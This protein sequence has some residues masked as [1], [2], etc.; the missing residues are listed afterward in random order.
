MAKDK[1]PTLEDD[2]DDDFGDDL[3]G[4]FNSNDAGDYSGGLG[5]EDGEDPRESRHPILKVAGDYSG[6]VGTSTL[7]GVGA[8]MADAFKDKMPNTSR[9]LGDLKNVA[10]EILR[11]KDDV[12]KDIRPTITQ[13]KVTLRRLAKYGEEV[14]PTGI[15]NRINKWLETQEED[16]KEPQSKEEARDQALSD[17]LNT[18]FEARLKVEQSNRKQDAIRE[19]ANNRIA[20]SRHAELAGLTADIRNQAMY[21]TAFLRST[22]TAYLRKD[23]ELKYRQL[24]LTEDIFETM[25]AQTQMQEDRLDAIIHNTALPDMAKVTLMDDVKFKFKEKLLNSFT[26][27]TSSYM[28]GIVNKIKENYVE[29]LKDNLGNVNDILGTFLDMKEMEEEMGMGS[30]PGGVKKSLVGALTGWLANTFIGKPT[31][32]K[33]LSKMP[34]DMLRRMEGFSK[35]GSTRMKLLLEQFRNG[36]IKSDWLNKHEDLASFLKDLADSVLPEID[37]GAGK[38]LN[39][40]YADPNAAGMIT[41]KFTSTVEE[42]IPGYL[43][44]QTNLL[45]AIATNQG[46]KATG[47]YKIYDWKTRK[48]I[49][50]KDF[51]N[52][53]ITE[54][55]GTKEENANIA[56]YN[57]EA[58]QKS[59]SYKALMDKDQ[60]KAVEISEMVEYEDLDTDLA[61]F[62]TLVA[63]QLRF[64][65][66]FPI[67]DVRNYADGDYDG[68]A[69]S[70]GKKIDRRETEAGFTEEDMPEWIKDVFLSGQIKHPKVLARYLTVICLTK[71]GNTTGV[72]TDLTNRIIDLIRQGVPQRAAKALRRM[73]DLGQTWLLTDE[74]AGYGGA[75]VNANTE[76]DIL[77]VSKTAR[78]HYSSQIGQKDLEMDL[79]YKDDGTLLK[80]PDKNGWTVFSKYWKKKG[81][82]QGIL[83]RAAQ[84]YSGLTGLA[85]GYR[86]LSEG[87]S[88]AMQTFRDGVERL[89]DTALERMKGHMGPWLYKMLSTDDLLPLRDCL[90]DPVRDWHDAEFREEITH[91]EVKR[92]L[93]AYPS[94]LDALLDLRS[95]PNTFKSIISEGLPEWLADMIDEIASDP[96]QV[97]KIRKYYSPAAIAERKKR[98]AERDLAEAGRIFTDLSDRIKNKK[99]LPQD[100]IAKVTRDDIRK[101]ARENNLSY[102]D[103]RKILNDQRNEKV[104]EIT[105]KQEEYFE[106]L[107]NRLIATYGKNPEERTEEQKKEMKRIVEFLKRFKNIPRVKSILSDHESIM[108]DEE[109]E[110]KEKEKEAEKAKKNEGK[111]SKEAKKARAKAD[112]ARIKAINKG[113]EARTKIEEMYAA[114]N[115]SNTPLDQEKLAKLKEQLN[116]GKEAQRQQDQ[117]EADKQAEE[118]RKAEEKKQKDAQDALNEIIEKYEKKDIELANDIVLGK[119]KSKKDPY[120]RS[121]NEEAKL[122]L[123]QEKRKALFD[124][125]RK[126]GGPLHKNPELWEQI[127]EL[128]DAIEQQ[129]YKHSKAVEQDAL[130]GPRHAAT[131]AEIDKK[132]QYD[133]EHRFDPTKGEE[134]EAIRSQLKATGRRAYVGV[135]NATLQKAYDDAYKQAY[136]NALNQFDDTDV[137]EK[138][139][140]TVAEALAIT[141]ARERGN[142][143]REKSIHMQVRGDTTHIARSDIQ[144]SDTELER[145]LK[146]TADIEE[147]TI[148]NPLRS[149]SGNIIKR[150]A[151]GTFLSRMFNKVSSADD[152]L[153]RG[154][155]SQAASIYKGNPTPEGKRLADACTSKAN[156]ILALYAQQGV[157]ISKYKKTY[158]GIVNTPTMLD[159]INL[160]GEHGK[161]AIIPLNS[162]QRSKE[163]AEETVKHTHGAQAA[164]ALKDA[165]EAKGPV[166]GEQKEAETVRDPGTILKDIE[167]GIQQGGTIIQGDKVIQD[168][169]WRPMMQSLFEELNKSIQ[170]TPDGSA[171]TSFRKQRENIRRRF[172]TQVSKLPD[173]RESEKGGLFNKL[174][175]KA[176]GLFAKGEKYVKNVQKEYYKDKAREAGI[177]DTAKAV[178]KDLGDTESTKASEIWDDLPNK[179]DGI[180]KS[181]KK[182]IALLKRIKK[183]GLREQLSTADQQTLDRITAAL[184]NKDL[185]LSRVSIAR[186]TSPKL[187]EFIR[188]Y[189]EKAKTL[190]EKK[191]S[192]LMSEAADY[193][194]GKATAAK[195]SIKE[196]YARVRESE[197]G[198]AVEGAAADAKEIATKSAKWGIEKLKEGAGLVG[199]LWNSVSR[200]WHGTFVN[201]EYGGLA[202]IAA[203]QLQIQ[204]GI[205]LQLQAGIPKAGEVS[206]EEA[207]SRL[208]ALSKKMGSWRRTGWEKIKSGTSWLWKT[209]VVSPAKGTLSTMRH[210][211]FN[212]KD[213]VYL[214]PGAGQ[215]PCQDDLLLISEEDFKKGVFFDKKGMHKVRSIQDINRPV[216]DA[217]GNVLIE[218]HHIKRGLTDSKGNPIRSRSRM[219]GRLLH[220]GT[221]GLAETA[222][223]VGKWG[224]GKIFNMENVRRVK[225]FF[226]S[227][228]GVLGGFL[229]KFE[230]IYNATKLA[231]AKTDDERAE[232]L[233]V[234]AKAQENGLVEFAN[235]KKPKDSYSIDSPLYWTKDKANGKRA[236]KVAITQVDIDEGLVNQDGTKLTS[237]LRKIGSVAR[238]MANAA[239]NFVGGLIGSPFKAVGTI[240]SGLWGATKWLFKGKDPYVDV[241]IPTKSGK[242]KGEIRRGHPRLTSMGIKA[243][244]YIYEDGTVVKSAW[245]LKDM[246][247]LDAET[248]KVIIKKEDIPLA[249]DIDGKPLTAFRGASVMGK[250]GRAG[251]AA[252][253][254][255]GR[256]VWKGVKGVGRFIKAGVNFITKGMWNTGSDIAN[257]VVESTK[258]ILSS[259]FGTGEKPLIRKDLEEIVGHRLV[260][261]NEHLTDIFLLLEDRLA[262]QT[263]KGDNNGT[264]ARDGSYQDYVKRMRA[265]RQ[266]RLDR[267]AKAEAARKK[268]ENGEDLTAEELA[269]LAAEAG[270]KAG[271]EAGDDGSML[272]TAASAALLYSLLPAKLKGAIRWPAKML[273]KLLPKKLGG[274]WL[275]R[276]S[277]AGEVADRFG[278]RA[279]QKAGQQGAGWWTRRKAYSQ[280][281]D[282]ARSK[283]MRRAATQA[284]RNAGKSALASVATKQGAKMGVRSLF[285]VGKGIGG[286]ASL[287]IGLVVGTIL[288][289]VVMDTWNHLDGTTAKRDDWEKMRFSAYGLSDFAVGKD[290][291]NTAGGTFTSA[292]NNNVNVIRDYVEDLEQEALSLMDGKREPFTDSD[293][294]DFCQDFKLLKSWY[295][296]GEDRFSAGLRESTFAKKQGGKVKQDSDAQRK[297]FFREWLEKRFFPI[298]T[299]YVYVMRSTIGDETEEDI[300][301]PATTL[302]PDLNQNAFKNF[303]EGIKEL[304]KRSPDTKE[305]S[306]SPDGYVYYLSMKY[307]DAEVQEEVKKRREQGERHVE[308]NTKKTYLDQKKEAREERQEWED[309]DR[310]DTDA[311]KLS[312][313]KSILAR[314]NAGTQDK[315]TDEMALHAESMRQA[316]TNVKADIEKSAELAAIQAGIANYT[317]D[318]YN[319][320]AVGE[321]I[322]RWYKVKYELYGADIKTQAAGINALESF[323]TDVYFNRTA[324]MNNDQAEK[325][326]AM[327]GLGEAKVTTQTAET[328]PVEEMSLDEIKNLSTE[329]GEDTEEAKRRRI[330]YFIN[331]Y[332]LR[333]WPIFKIYVAIIS[334]FLKRDTQLTLKD[335]KAADNDVAF[336][337]F[338]TEAKAVLSKNPELENLTPSLAGYNQL[339]SKLKAEVEK[340]MTETTGVKNPEEEKSP[341]DVAKA[342]EEAKRRESARLAAERERNKLNHDRLMESARKADAAKAAA[343]GGIPKPPTTTT[344][345]QTQTQNK[346]IENANK[347]ATDRALA[348]AEQNLSGQNGNVNDKGSSTGGAGADAG[349]VIDLSHIKASDIPDGG[350][351]DIGSYV[352]Q[353]E[354]GKKGPSAIGWDKGGG[355][356]YGSYQLAAGQNVKMI[357]DEFIPWLKSHGGEFGKQL[358]A[359]LEQNKPYD[360]GSTHGKAP[361][362]WRQFAGVEGGQALNKLEHKFWYEKKYLPILKRLSK[363]PGGELLNSDRGLQEALWSISVQHG[364]GGPKTNKGAY[365][366]F[367]S[368]YKPG[369][370]AADWLRAIYADRNK[371]YPGYRSRYDAELGVVLGLSAKGGSAV[372]TQI[373]GKDAANTDGS[374]STPSYQT[375]AQD[376]LDQ[377]GAHNLSQSG[378]DNSAMTPGEPTAQADGGTGKDGIER[379]TNSDVVTSPFGPR[380]VPGGSKNHKGIDL[381]ARTGDPIKAIDKGKV[382]SAGG[383]WN[384]VMVQHDDGLV[385][386]YMHLSKMNVKPGQQV[387]AGQELGKAGGKGPKGPTQYA[388]HLHFGV[389]QNGQWLDP[390]KFLEN[391]GVSL[392]R[393]GEPGNSA[394][395]PQSDAGAPGTTGNEQP[396][397]DIK[398]QEAKAGAPA[399][400]E[401]VREEK[402]K[403]QEAAAGSTASQTVTAAATEAKAE[404]DKVLSS[405]GTTPPSATESSSTTTSTTTPAETSGGSEPAAADKAAETSMKVAEQTSAEN[406]AGN[407][408]S[409]APVVTTETPQTAANASNDAT[410][411]AS[412][413]EL[414]NIGDILNAIKAVIERQETASTA[415]ALSTTTASAETKPAT[416]ETPTSEADAIGQ[417][418]ATALAPLMQSISDLVGQIASSG[419]TPSKDSPRMTETYSTKSPL[420]ETR[421]NQWSD[422]YKNKFA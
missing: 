286:I 53:A 71:S 75:F 343:G 250:L 323:S 399:A 4:L 328:K 127:Q 282:A 350:G 100:E 296:F 134:Q 254:M 398:I 403:Q 90:F 99:A 135:Y 140:R 185:K 224:A 245:G 166:K 249:C 405:S 137:A 72:Y 17:N 322:A 359:Q 377:A 56:R 189:K 291:T 130:R 114:Y 42:V 141:T 316:L 360:T 39:E 79:K 231:A 34:P 313:E 146:E 339:Q 154:L 167:R 391:S 179:K 283:F 340:V 412:L 303:E 25:K 198:Q 84:S 171:K 76:G 14:V 222:W 266:A 29:P 259:I 385:S 269:L 113:L 410:S 244:K 164:E 195:E 192:E 293:I 314:A 94:C 267:A 415:T 67:E 273:G 379:P 91:L 132:K 93:M 390:E 234:S 111:E 12:V 397:E 121:G 404:A 371:K 334:N 321:K 47:N 190:S 74:N 416:P 306:L 9:A 315:L 342:R 129:K 265:K 246:A 299:L 110:R 204:E 18:I 210:T 395:A 276:H 70:H 261:V 230:D 401:A 62:V 158:G 183:E 229:H 36:E 202:D 341:E 61:K 182:F 124:A 383:G 411:E 52:R 95:N 248:R 285:K 278:T 26:D 101:Y 199:D 37:R 172:R 212:Q 49:T 367:A 194:K 337:K 81:G 387:T 271:A 150:H 256:G 218:R 173:E 174:R 255:V 139:A 233:L 69:Y 128:D 318:D 262:D 86:N 148:S 153:I 351:G 358:A 116:A 126:P 219:I 181:G 159:D 43:A 176:T 168:G 151:V 280:A 251:L 275:T 241:Y 3:E 369:M 421:S 409:G 239:T 41:K 396:A 309:E 197:F 13:T 54:M 413:V 386:Q 201:K 83:D 363:L 327:F 422:L 349:P 109:E 252:I 82:M 63:N 326:A 32:Q 186:G 305:L 7:A 414:K 221:F 417:A 136:E 298:F 290:R 97:E 104:S 215:E 329:T 162:N 284:S 274:A 258:G 228:F 330:A 352:K 203:M 144:V 138:V 366:M 112:K 85:E 10:S 236:G 50:K 325:F 28:G 118:E 5:G 59:K 117:I 408:G 317:L 240:L 345:Q 58:V 48:F 297:Q 392:H 55:F 33:I 370:S 214:A 80:V 15:Y 155:Y 400:S 77:E 281:S 65:E 356:S 125:Y 211:V 346:D 196:T 420:R 143:A 380:N 160:V 223:D 394:M 235:G 289:N 120:A 68:I 336:E 44:M 131:Q 253:G 11:L 320:K 161:E 157:D 388:P 89:T 165:K 98:H 2:W 145:L 324:P 308:T 257:W 368:T 115:T 333:F 389:K 335:L 294:E 263:V 362:V 407:S 6:V 22:F 213:A 374:E 384:T 373:P 338:T 64:S 73:D 78:D 361:D 376:A 247:I 35:N 354:S 45:E 232:A 238:R 57:V 331:W 277:R 242:H 419:G 119:F 406:N 270:G 207:H 92:T 364:N 149:A 106:V 393:K 8:G 96:K 191:A 205:L 156:H 107:E 51:Q 310:W 87:V 180:V 268:R 105:G 103:A 184:K 243:G 301:D 227:P 178:A 292:H 16:R 163:L 402:D 123:L 347:E 175:A 353:F 187:A 344:N 288:E 332:N 378:G 46:A 108:K 220:K 206:P 188:W 312:I 279:A 348:S 217:N 66:G 20:A 216:Y 382:L 225:N 209:G 264:G 142:E 357:S 23:L 1:D 381:R 272:D 133:A 38:A 21:H 208:I 27:A 24:Y 295:D 226:L 307:G 147:A 31:M 319:V 88:S 311:F 60:D 287:G 19:I 177:A 30:G 300:F 237:K 304:Y 355:T 302:D 40:V 365:D 170:N 122:N 200:N 193:V 418:V 372:A 169:T 260:E 152:K 375:A 102:T